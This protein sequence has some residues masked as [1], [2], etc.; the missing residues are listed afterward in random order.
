MSG[1]VDLVC[2][3]TPLQP[4]AHRGDTDANDEGQ[5]PGT[6]AYRARN[7]RIISR[8]AAG[9]RDAKRKAAHS[10]CARYCTLYAADAS[11]ALLQ[12]QKRVQYLPTLCQ[13]HSAT[14]VLAPSRSTMLL[15]CQLPTRPTPDPVVYGT[16]RVCMCRTRPVRCLCRSK[17][18]A[19][20][21]T[22]VYMEP[23][24]RYIKHTHQGS[25]LFSSSSPQPA[26]NN[27]PTSRG[28]STAPPLFNTPYTH[29]TTTITTPTTT[30]TTPAR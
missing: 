8:E 21:Y 13:V 26:P 6:G 2:A 27:T 28:G 22:L 1:G 5:K 25:L 23:C 29:C 16:M 4:R 20:A 10:G 17:V 11:A 19:F 9:I 3:S 24:M 7:T 15:R 12:R 18:L 30:H 14:R